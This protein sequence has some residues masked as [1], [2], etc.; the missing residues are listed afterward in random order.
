LVPFFHNYIIGISLNSPS[1][2]SFLGEISTCQAS[3]ISG[4]LIQW[5]LRGR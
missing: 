3:L 2:V 5:L 1:K 4:K